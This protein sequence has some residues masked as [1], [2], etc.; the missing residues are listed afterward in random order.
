MTS[1]LPTRIEQVYDNS[2]EAGRKLLDIMGQQAKDNPYDDIAYVLDKYHKGKD[3]ES[4][5]DSTAIINKALE[6][7]LTGAQALEKAKQAGYD[8]RILGSDPVQEALRK[9]RASIIAQRA[10]DRLAETYNTNKLANQFIAEME[11]Y[12]A[13]IGAGGAYAI[14]SWF[15]QNRDKIKANPNVFKQVLDHAVKSGY[16]LTTF[17]DPVNGAGIVAPSWGDLQSQ[18]NRVDT[19]MHKMNKYGFKDNLSPEETLARTN[20]DKWVEHQ[21]KLFGHEGSSFADFRDNMYQGY[22]ALKGAFPELD[23]EVI[24]YA[25]SQNIDTEFFSAYGDEEDIKVDNAT[26]WLTANARD[27]D[28]A[29]NNYRQLADIKSSLGKAIKDDAYRT[30]VSSAEAVRQQINDA[31]RK[32]VLTQKQ[33]DEALARLVTKINS[34]NAAY[35]RSF[36]DAN[37]LLKIIGTV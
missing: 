15:D 5:A 7:G 19:A 2:G 10:E 16:D 21:G 27:F 36:K 28:K 14:G 30:A 31:V 29:R 13:R 32:G 9:S 20:F 17:S 11:D 37:S 6:E 35:S 24:L 25:M 34:A 22:K 18:Y 4:I 3:A 23:D 1:L 12:K 8:S 26:Q 33:G